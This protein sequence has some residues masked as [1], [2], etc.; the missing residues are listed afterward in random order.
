MADLDEIRRMAEEHPDFVEQ[1]VEPLSP[2][3]ADEFEDG[4]TK[5]ELASHGLPPLPKVG[6]SVG[7][8]GAHVATLGSDTL[9][10]IHLA[11][12]DPLANRP[13]LANPRQPSRSDH[14]ILYPRST[15]TLPTLAPPI[16]SNAFLPTPS[17]LPPHFL[18]GLGRVQG[19]GARLFLLL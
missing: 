3:L 5:E 11:A 2:D 10:V 1:A 13:T 9:A 17:P 14:T 19:R 18:P 16:I 7:R 15:H 4:V 8:S 6:G 12:P